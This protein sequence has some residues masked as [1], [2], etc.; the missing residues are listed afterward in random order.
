[1]SFRRNVIDHSPVPLIKIAK[2]IRTLGRL[3]SSGV[4]IKELLNNGRPIMLELGSGSKEGANGW[5]TLDVVPGCDLY[6]DLTNG[7]P[8]P[9]NTVEAIYSSHL[10]EHLTFKEA[11]AL[12]DECMRVLVPAGR[13]S[14]CVPNGRLYLQAYINNELLDRKQFVYA[15]A[16]NDTTRIDYVNY[17]AYMDGVHKYMF[18]EEN[19]IFILRAKG[20]TK[21]RLREFDASIDLKE[22][23][24]ESIY[25]EGV[26][27]G[28]TR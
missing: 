7:I 10:F 22:R 11:Q 24:F 20:F 1:M 21:V 28:K 3:R 5:T 23:D 12:L 19:L 9:E 27:V 25:A 18:D 15:P 6:C 4:H 17:I 13:F 8:F 14:I 26:K 2:G 16:F